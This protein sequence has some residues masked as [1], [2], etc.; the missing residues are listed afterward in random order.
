MTEEA[1]AVEEELP[2]RSLLL[3]RGLALAVMLFIL[4]VGIIINV[5][6]T[7]LPTWT[8]VNSTVLSG[9]TLKPRVPDVMQDR[10]SKQDMQW[11]DGSVDEQKAEGL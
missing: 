5:L 10:M 4:A 11:T 1:P 3:R 9:I 8:S 7:N 6:I 2:Y